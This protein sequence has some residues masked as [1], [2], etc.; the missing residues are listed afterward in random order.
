MSFE[1]GLLRKN[2]MEVPNLGFTISNFGKHLRIVF[3]LFLEKVTFVLIRT[4]CIFI[5]F[6]YRYILWELPNVTNPLVEQIVLFYI[7]T[8]STEA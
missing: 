3:S 2:K 1:D 5:N 8:K 6:L 4:R 7:V